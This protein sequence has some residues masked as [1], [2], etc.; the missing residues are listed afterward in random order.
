MQ[1]IAWSLHLFVFVLPGWCIPWAPSP[2]LQPTSS[3]PT[4]PRPTRPCTPPRQPPRLQLPLLPS[5][6]FLCLSLF[7]SYN[8]YKRRKIN[9]AGRRTRTR[10][11]SCDYCIFFVCA[12][13][14]CRFFGFW[15]L[16]SACCL[17]S[18]KK[19]TVN[20]SICAQIISLCRNMYFSCVLNHEW[21]FKT[22]S[23][24][25]HSV[26]IKNIESTELW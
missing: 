8:K 17:E 14:D 2:S 24:W 22:S 7:L 10:K 19:G 18:A 23:Y 3:R 4:P 5:F 25:Y 15:A 6:P 11:L 13:D 21:N 1:N 20:Y 16:S 12:C 9:E 26:D